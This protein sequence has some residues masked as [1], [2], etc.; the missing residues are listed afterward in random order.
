MK[1]EELRIQLTE[2]DKGSSG[3]QG[4]TEK[5]RCKVKKIL[6]LI[7]GFTFLNIS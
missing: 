3:C 4:P 2:L 7:D 5:F 6:L 1:T